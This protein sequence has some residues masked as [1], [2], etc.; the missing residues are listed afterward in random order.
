M[1]KFQKSPR[2][3]T[4][5]TILALW[6]A[7]HS[8]VQKYGLDHE[9]ISLVSNQNGQKNHGQHFLLATRGVLG[10]EK[11]VKTGSLELFGDTVGYVHQLK[12]HGEAYL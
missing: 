7:V 5:P 4:E 6:Y 9:Q 3:Q 1:K 2:P 10:L 12:F 8:I 11:V